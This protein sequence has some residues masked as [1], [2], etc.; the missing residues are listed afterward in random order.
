MRGALLTASRL[1]AFVPKWVIG[2]IRWLEKKRPA[3]LQLQYFLALDYFYWLGVWRAFV[4]HPEAA[5]RFAL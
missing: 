3:S 4:E 2:Y 5:Q 1:F